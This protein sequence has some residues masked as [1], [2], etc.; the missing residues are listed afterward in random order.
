MHKDQKLDFVQLVII[1]LSIY[2][3]CSLIISTF[4]TLPPEI[5]HLLNIIDHAICIVFLIDFFYRF[6]HAPNKLQ[7]MKWGWIDLISSIPTIQAFRVGRLFRL[8]RLLRIVRA[9]RSTEIL[10]EYIFRKKTKGA[11]TTASIIA[12]LMVIFSSIAILEVEHAPHSNIK[13][14]E[15]ALWWAF[16]TITTV[17]YGDKYPVTTEGRIIAVIVMTT[18]VG[19]FGTFTGYIA[20]WFVE[21][22]T[23]ERLEEEEME[24]RK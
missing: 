24:A 18:G 20:S 4:F 21:E 16:V 23:E 1:V 3:L 13:S 5:L 15:D 19:L 17:G 2:I 9:F 6:F 11:F 10:L 7:F 22:R 12:I 8:I 14:A